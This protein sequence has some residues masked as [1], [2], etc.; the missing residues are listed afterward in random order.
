MISL[1]DA[2]PASSA[3]AYY[4]S[5]N[6]YTESQNQH[7]SAWEGKGAAALGLTG[8]VEAAAFTAVLEGKLPD[9]SVVGPKTG[10]NRPGLDLTFSP[11][12]SVSLVAL[13]GGD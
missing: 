4:A 3:A 6:Y 13:V 1:S 5:D 8:K 10:K 2:K 7:A 11:S 12:K 9:G